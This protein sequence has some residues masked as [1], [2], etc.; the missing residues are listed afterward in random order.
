[1]AKAQFQG[2]ARGKGFTS[3]DPGY[4]GLSRMREQQQQELSDLKESQKEAIRRD[5]Q[6]EA[7]IE[8]I[9]RNEEANAKEINIEDLTS[10]TRKQAL[11]IEQQGKEQNYRAEVAKIE[12]DAKNLESIINFSK[13]A[14]GALKTYQDKTWENTANS[15]YAYYMN[16]GLSMEDQ[17]MMDMLE[18]KN[19]QD[20]ENLEALADRMREDGYSIEEEIYVRGKNKAS[21]YGR[22]K[23]YSIM[24]GENFGEF[25]QTKL[26]EMNVQTVEQKQAAL[27]VLRMEYLKAHKLYGVSADF[28]DPM[29]TKMRNTSN[30][31]VNR[32]KLDRD[33][34]F[35]QRRTREK[36][37]VLTASLT[38]QSLNEYY[39]QKTRERKA[40]GTR[41]TPSEAKAAVFALLGDTRKF[42]NDAEVL[43]LLNETPL[44]NM[45][46]T[47][48]KANAGL[49]QD[50]IY[51]RTLNKESNEQKTAQIIAGRKKAER[52]EFKTFIET[53]WNGDLNVLNKGIDQ[54]RSTGHSNEE[55]AEFLPY[56]DESIQRRTDGNYWETH[57][58][59]KAEEHRLTTEDLKGP[60]V[61]KDIRDKYW[62]EAAEKEAIFKS[63]NI[64][65][66][67]T[68]AFDKALRAALKAESIDDTVHSSITQAA[69]VAETQFRGYLLESNDVEGSIT[70]VLEN[71]EKG[72]GDFNV[73]EPGAKG[74][75]MA[76]FGAFVPGT[77][78]NAAKIIPTESTDEK[79]KVINELEDQPDLISSELYIKVEDLKHIRDSIADGKSFRL[80]E[81]CYVISQADPE[82]FGSPLDVWHQQLK[83]AELDT[84][85][86]KVDDFIS[87]LYRDSSD[88]QGKEMIKNLRTLSD[89]RKSIQVTYNPNSVRDPKF[90]SPNVLKKIQRPALIPPTRE[91]LKVDYSWDY[92]IKEGLDTGQ[93]APYSLK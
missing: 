62:A 10:A 18:D 16:H 51:Q 75:Q 80:P 65:K 49:V 84:L 42:P 60:Y 36:E 72:Y 20:G 2:Y 86:L 40:D 28:L 56:R 33:V 77:H 66:R 8:R 87:T 26:S 3:I 85:G 4:I 17:I 5:E 68:P 50:L 38:P 27:E 64:K 14:A 59:K 6:F 46:S 31:I 34:S 74:S 81:I 52:G 61:P 15:S 78:K 12:N 44:G 88:P 1:M 57:F 92:V 25:A 13:T 7:N 70:K 32:A 11:K 30:V 76:F 47:W 21:D 35:T 19:W 43:R 71:I 9:N 69:H 41:F 82:I 58:A 45:N 24:A 93:F 48:G 91:E 22:L 90:Y 73:I 55:L 89:L 63:A 29:F 23:A 53:E 79:L 67:V 39:I 37:Q 54:L 83:A